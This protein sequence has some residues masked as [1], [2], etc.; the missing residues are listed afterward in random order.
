MTG[1]SLQLTGF[2]ELDDQLQRLTRSTAKAAL[3]RGLGKAAQP[4]VEKM[5]AAA[6]EDTGALK[7]SIIASTRSTNGDAGKAAYAATMRAGGNRAE[8]GMALRAV[9]SA[10]AGEKPSV[11]LFVGVSGRPASV[12]HLYEFGSQHQPARP[13]MRPTWD[14]DKEAMLARIKAELMN[15]IAKTIARATRRGTLVG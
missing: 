2:K 1:F 3:R 10:N 13:F 6:P 11:E 5:R 4:L 8:A 14:S 12:A 7:K 15:D 9:N